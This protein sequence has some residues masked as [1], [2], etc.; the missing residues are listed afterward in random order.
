M[1]DVLRVA[2]AYWVVLALF[3]I[4]RWAMSSVP[5]EKGHHVLSIVTM[6]FM[7]SAFFAACCRAWRGYPW[8]RAALLGLVFG[9]S[10]QIVI[11]LS[12]VA[13]YLLGL[14]TYFNHPRALNA[15]AALSLGEALRVRAGGLVAGPIANAVM[16]SIGWLLGTLLPRD[17]RSGTP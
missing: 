1:S 17:Q 2:R 7:A 6:T 12:T 14:E 4:G 11:F 9:L 13:S 3:T 5:Y 8:G 15:P 10:A 16:A